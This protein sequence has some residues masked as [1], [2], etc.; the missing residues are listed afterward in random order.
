MGEARMTGSVKLV[1]LVGEYFPS[2]FLFFFFSL[3]TLCSQC[4][5]TRFG[6]GLGRF[7]C[8]D[9]CCVVQTL[10]PSTSS[11]CQNCANRCS[12]WTISPLSC[13]AGRTHRGVS[14]HR[15]HCLCSH[16]SFKSWVPLT[17]RFCPKDVCTITKQGDN[18]RVD[19]TLVGFESMSWIYGKKAVKTVVLAMNN[20]MQV[21]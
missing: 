17:G 5:S 10:P 14:S 11:G 8:F 9:N 6:A 12:I 21:K 1:R 16:W 13:G 3:T 18:L 15:T 19:F 4:S 2:V 20:V 7:L